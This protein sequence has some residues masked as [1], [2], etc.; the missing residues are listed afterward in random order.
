M[1]FEIDSSKDIILKI[2]FSTYTDLLGKVTDY[3]TNMLNNKVEE[4]SFNNK[5]SNIIYL[6]QIMLKA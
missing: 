3:I 2:T 6:L 1:N 5:R 4:F